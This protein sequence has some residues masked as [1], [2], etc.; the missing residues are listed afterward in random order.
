MSHVNPWTTDRDTR[1]TTPAEVLLEL[2]RRPSWWRHAECRGADTEIFFP[3]RGEDTAE[4]MAYCRR[5]P[6]TEECLAWAL[7]DGHQPGV[8]GGMSE[9][10]RRGLLS[11]HRTCKVCGSLIT[12]RRRVSLCSDTCE[13]H[14][15][16]RS[17]YASNQRRKV[18]A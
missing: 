13:R 10:Q 8:Y 4:A 2:I 14:A 7:A 5:C 3:G 18:D 6:V 15:R 17:Q 1:S 16:K 12:E 9:R 11:Q